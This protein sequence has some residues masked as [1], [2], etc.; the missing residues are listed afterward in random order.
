MDTSICGDLKPLIYFWLWRSSTSDWSL[1]ALRSL[2]QIIFTLPK[3]MQKYMKNKHF[4]CPWETHGGKKK[5]VR[6]QGLSLDVSA[7][8]RLKQNTNQEAPGTRPG[9]TRKATRKRQD[10]RGKPPGSTKTTSCWMAQKVPG[11]RFHG[12][13][14]HLPDNSEIHYFKKGVWLKKGFE[15][16]LKNDIS[17]D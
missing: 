9:R 13:Q 1:F 10:A 11:G 4:Q 7:T 14:T 17:T 3:F 2:V 16:G 8:K 15:N 12:G 5:H 6:S